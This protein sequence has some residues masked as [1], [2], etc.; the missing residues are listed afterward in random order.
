[1]FQEAKSSPLLNDTE[2]T[3]TLGAE[4]ALEFGTWRSLMIDQ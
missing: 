3:G 2:K 1:M 4:I